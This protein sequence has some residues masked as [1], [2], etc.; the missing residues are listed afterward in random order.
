VLW[1]LLR[2]ARPHQWVKNLFVLAPLVFAKELFE[3]GIALQSLFGFAIFCLA[4]STV[5]VINDLAD[6]EA[7]RAH[8]VKQGRPIAS[9]RVS[10]G[11]AR[12]AAGILAVTVL[13]GGYLLEPSFALTAILYL[14]LNLAYSFRLKHVAYVD[15][16]CIATGFELRVLAG[17]FA[18]RVEPSAYLLIVTFLL[19]I[20]LG[21]GK[22]M[23][24][25]THGER[26]EKQRASLSAYG[27][28]TL[29]ALLYA[30]GVLTV[31]A[32]VAYTLDAHTRAFF[33]TDY[34]VVTAF[35]ALLGVGRFLHLVRRR[36][37]AESPTEEMLRDVP[38][39]ANL[40]LWVVAVLATIYFS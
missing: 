25:L 33:Q 14:T 35:F 17:S 11:A 15:V 27:R 29:T 36:P 39:L 16:L 30:A 5:Y 3:V 28:R 9:G 37:M 6:V 4:S 23:H 38:F 26:A 32:Y 34:L 10:I 13:V 21:L 40:A 2:T 1:G 20:F 12:S 19:A 18:A 7:D 31:G 24:E 8:P 22:R